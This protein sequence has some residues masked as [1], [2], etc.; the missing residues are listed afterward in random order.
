MPSKLSKRKL[1]SKLRPRRRGTLDF[2]QVSL[3]T[4]KKSCFAQYRYGS[5]SENE[6]VAVLDEFHRAG[7]CLDR[8]YFMDHDLHELWLDGQLIGLC[9]LHVGASV[10]KSGVEIDT[11]LQAI[12]LL[13]KFRGNGLSTALI[14]CILDDLAAGYTATIAEAISAQA[15]EIIF[16]LHA[17]IESEEGE[18][19][20][21]HLKNF[22]EYYIEKAKAAFQIKIR[23]QIE[24]G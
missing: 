2:I 18:W 13:K 16:V 14:D 19:V 15:V 12:F 7:D 21:R 17:D 24:A 23:L 3:Q 8:R 5:A 10:L 11:S 22:V 1:N 20:F 9:N 4:R 6:K